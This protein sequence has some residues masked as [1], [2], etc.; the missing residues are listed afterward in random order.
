MTTGWFIYLAFVLHDYIT[1]WV[2][3]ITTLFYGGIFSI[4]L[5]NFNRVSKWE[6]V[7]E[8]L[9]KK[10]DG[11]TARL[12]QRENINLFILLNYFFNLA[13]I[14]VMRKSTLFFAWLI[15]ILLIGLSLLRELEHTTYL[16]EQPPQSKKNKIATVLIYSLFLFI[17][18]LSWLNSFSVSE[19][20][21]QTLEPAFGK[22]FAIFLALSIWLFLVRF[23]WKEWS[24]Q[25]FFRYLQYFILALSLA[26]FAGRFAIYNIQR[27]AVYYANQMKHDQYNDPVLI[28]M[29]DF[30]RTTDFPDTVTYKQNYG[31]Q[32]I[33]SKNFG[34]YALYYNEGAH[35]SV[36]DSRYTFRSD[37]LFMQI[38][39]KGTFEIY[40]MSFLN[41]PGY[42][43]LNDEECLRSIQDWVKKIEEE[44]LKAHSKPFIN[45]QFIYNMLYQ[46]KFK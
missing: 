37:E 17:F 33:K 28:A 20:S 46:N 23:T 13:A 6:E 2:G 25:R 3:G 9:Q 38:S 15:L 40:T 16:E 41:K 34:G 44:T 10:Y 14:P 27:H 18:T 8:D 21:S 45:L 24:S 32:E 5:L 29:M 31:V 12:L 30:A 19:M 1:F 35:S 4:R 36:Y 26:F 7:P 11:F 39:D 22:I 42:K 43:V